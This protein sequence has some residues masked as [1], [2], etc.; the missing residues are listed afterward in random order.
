MTDKQRS[1]SRA[2]RILARTL[3][4][5]LCPRIVVYI[6][7]RVTKR[8]LYRN[9][10][11]FVCFP[12]VTFSMRKGHNF[13][14]NLK[15][16]KEDVASFCRFQLEQQCLWNSNYQYYGGERI[17]FLDFLLQQIQISVVEVVLLI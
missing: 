5:F 7:P 6:I 2:S 13:V 10:V 1:S 15:D 11:L 4:S 9:I 3:R 17:V 14:Q 16:D 8:I 12:G